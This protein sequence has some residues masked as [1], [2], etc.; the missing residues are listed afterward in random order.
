MT[1][2]QYIDYLIQSAEMIES[3]Q[4]SIAIQ[5]VELRTLKHFMLLEKAQQ[6]TEKA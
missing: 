1:A 5:P 3:G 2:L 4:T 6:E